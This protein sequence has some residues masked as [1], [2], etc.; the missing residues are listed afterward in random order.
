MSKKKS[1]MDIKNIISEGIFSNIFNL[2]KWGKKYK[3]KPLD[4]D[5]KAA[6]KDPKFRRMLS[7]FDKFYKD[8]MKYDK[9]MQKKYGYKSKFD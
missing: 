8:F 5:E 7:D 4:R 6:L 3:N 9:E 1:Y 2:L